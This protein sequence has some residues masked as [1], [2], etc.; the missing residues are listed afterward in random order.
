M[1]N[2]EPWRVST[3]KGLDSIKVL[4]ST[5][6]SWLIG[7]WAV[8]AFVLL[9][10]F[11][12][13]WKGYH[14][15]DSNQTIQIPIVKSYIDSELYLGDTLLSVR[16]RYTSLL[17]PILGHLLPRVEA[18][19]PVYFALY[20]LSLALMFSAGWAISRAVFP[21]PRAAA[22]VVFLMMAQINS[23]GTDRSYD[24][25]FTHSQLA[26]ALLLWSIYLFIR[27][28]YVLAYVLSGVVFN[29]H[30]SY[31]LYVLCMFGFYHLVHERSDGFRHLIKP[32]TGFLVTALPTLVWTVWAME[33]MT[34]EWLELLRIR[35]SHHSFPLTFSPKQY[36][37]YLVILAFGVL[38]LRDKP[39][40]L[41]HRRFLLFVAALVLLCILGVIF[42][43]WIS[44]KVVLLAQ[45]FRS[46][47]F[48]TFIV[49]L[50]ASHYF[51]KSWDR[52]LVR[53]IAVV[54]SVLAFQF[55]PY[56]GFMLPALGLFVLTEPRSSQSSWRLTIVAS[57]ILV[58][59]R[60]GGFEIHDGLAIGF[61]GSE[62]QKMA[63]PHMMVLLA[64]LVAAWSVLQGG[65]LL[66]AAVGTVVILVLTVYSVPSIY[67]NRRYK[68]LH[69]DYVAV[70]L[71]AKE[72]TPKTATFLTPASSMGFRVFSERAVVS[73]WKDGTMQ[74][75]GT[76]FALQ[77]WDRQQD[78]DGLEDLSP[79]DII[80]LAVKY[81][82][83]Y[84]VVPST[85]SFPFRKLYDD[86]VFVVYQ[87]LGRFRPSTQN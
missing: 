17:Y 85:M 66:R 58:G 12:T 38:G 30:G 44:I 65:R 68:Y 74:N 70:Q 56:L 37:R 81:G 76:D 50:Y 63:A 72:N 69:D 15:G 75:F 61:L 16:S 49:L 13:W 57:F 55:F 40:A 2:R 7:G 78:L 26:F 77:W 6:T 36:S 73:E 1:S 82:A 39:V 3:K 22:V 11:C 80:E 83:E 34:N 52:G 59:A 41:H 14:Y 27:K 28:R 4:K 21:D 54:L 24:T 20:I 18:I 67:H 33:P 71:W 35:S 45:F 48:L 5:K 51:V 10:L 47:R 64:L 8:L 23:L 25:Q 43:H 31:V 53:R 46:T 79:E 9:A 87:L 62:I 86:K 42:A 32:W 84:L 29:L 19:E 60:W